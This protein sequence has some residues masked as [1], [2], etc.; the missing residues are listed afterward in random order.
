MT[1]RTEAAYPGRR[2]AAAARTGSG[3][4]WKKL[5]TDRYLY[6]LALPGMAFILLFDYVPMYGIVLAFQDYNPFAGILHS[7]W[8]GFAHFERLFKHPDFWLVLRNTLVISLMNLVLFFPTPIVLALLLN[9]IRLKWFQRTIQTIIYLP[10]FVSWVVICS[11]TITLMNSEGLVTQIV[12]ALG[13]PKVQLLLDKQLFWGMITLQSI[14]K[15]AG[16]G[17]IIFLAALAG[18]NPELYEAARVDGANRWHQMKS[19]TIPALMNTVVVLLLL[20]IGHIMSLSFDQLYMMGNPMVSDVAE[21]F[22]TYVFKAGVL[23]GNF[24]FA[25]AVGLFKSAVGLVLIL[26]SNFLA[27]KTSDN[28]LF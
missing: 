13:F 23:Q 20:R 11:L 12:H 8:V 18:I 26:G 10:H 14:W 21:V 3:K 22:D 16:W 19:I 7:D 4:L 17:T 15:E 9:E 6:L 27:K 1:T 28:Y 2:P 5:W 24:S 25:A